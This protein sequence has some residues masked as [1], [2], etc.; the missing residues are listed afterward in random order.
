MSKEKE[1]FLS[2]P[3]EEHIQILEAVMALYGYICAQANSG[4]DPQTGQACNQIIELFQN[5]HK[6]LYKLQRALSP[7]NFKFRDLD[8]VVMAT[9]RSLS[10]DIINT[11][12]KNKDPELLPVEMMLALEKY[13]IIGRTKNQDFNEEDELPF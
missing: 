5:T 10:N 6:P 11:I 2:V 1:Y 8:K 13:E 9:R 12:L 4:T 7:S 3:K